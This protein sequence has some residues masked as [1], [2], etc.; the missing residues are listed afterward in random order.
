M[1]T[2]TEVIYAS[3]N[4]SG[5]QLNLGWYALAECIAAKTH[6]G[7]A[8]AKWCGVK[9]DARKPRHYKGKEILDVSKLRKIAA[10]RF[11]NCGNLSEIT[12]YSRQFFWN[13]L[14]RGSCH[15]SEEL[16]N[17]IERSLNLPTGSLIVK[18]E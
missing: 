15:F 16:I 7:T 4:P 5:I 17:H 3:N 6:P 11:M 2:R 14:E 9:K 13:I 18:G 10:E 8:L 12:G 1:L